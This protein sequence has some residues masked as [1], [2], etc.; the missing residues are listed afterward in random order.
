MT[1]HL[2]QDHGWNLLRWEDLHL[3]KVLDFNH[4]A[5]LLVDD[6]EWPWFNILL[7]SRVIKPTSNQTPVWELA[8]SNTQSRVIWNWLDI[9]DCIS[10]VHSSLI[11]CGF[12]D[13]TFLVGEGNEWGSGETTLLVGDNF[14]IA[15]FI[16][17]NARICCACAIWLVRQ[18]VEFAIPGENLHLE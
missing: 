15:P 3:P 8:R 10:W 1:D 9:E 11:L 7:D 12:T 14:Y 2:C 6:L 17:G 18:K 16:V 4:R 13:Q 5:S